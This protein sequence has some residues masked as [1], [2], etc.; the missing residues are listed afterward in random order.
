MRGFDPDHLVIPPPRPGA[1]V[2]LAAK[3]D[4]RDTAEGPAHRLRT[5]GNAV[6]HTADSQG[7]AARRSQNPICRRPSSVRSFSVARPLKSTSKSIA[8]KSG[9]ERPA[10]NAAF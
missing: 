7:A 6:R 5:V 8:A 4:A 9:A 2:R 10:R 1:C 3:A